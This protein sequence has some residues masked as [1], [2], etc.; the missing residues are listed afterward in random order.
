MTLKT[1]GI[2]RV[3]GDRYAG[4]WPREAFRKHGITYEPAEQ[5]KSRIYANFLPLLNSRRADLLDE[6]RL[7]A[8]LVGLERRTARG[9]RDRIDHGPNAHDDVANAV[10]GALDL[11]TVRSGNP[12]DICFRRQ[13]IRRT[14]FV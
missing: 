3:R 6:P 12:G 7:V 13:R 1:Y 8:Q 10:A 2:G 4:E 5:P 9:G 14:P 11:I